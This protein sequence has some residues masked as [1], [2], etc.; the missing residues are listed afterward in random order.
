ML[1]RNLIYTAMTRAKKLL[2]L[3]GTPKALAM[4]VKHNP[5]INRRSFLA[6]RLKEA[7]A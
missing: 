5:S 1:Q 3:V 2:L 4:A 6:A 7:V